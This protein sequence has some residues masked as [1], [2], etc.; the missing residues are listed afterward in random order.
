MVEKK[1]FPGCSFQGLAR[2]S[3]APNIAGLALVF[4]YYSCATL[5]GIVLRASDPGSPHEHGGHDR[6]HQ[7]DVVAAPVWL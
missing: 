1:C 7:G 6:G 5:H 2:V 3:P 4:C